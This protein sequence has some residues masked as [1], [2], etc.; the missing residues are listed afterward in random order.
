MDRDAKNILRIIRN[1]AAGPAEI[2]GLKVSDVHLD[3]PIPFVHLQF[4]DVRR[5][6][7]KDRVRKLPLVGLA[8]EAAKDALKAATGENLFNS[9]TAGDRTIDVM[10]NRLNKTIRDAGIEDR[11][12]Y[13][14]R[15]S[16]V[17]AMRDSNANEYLQLRLISHAATST[18]DRVYGTKDARLSDMQAAITKALDH[19]G[20][21]DDDGDC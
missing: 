13:S 4:N 6:K 1:T 20:Q 21:F 19:L 16:M 9:I 14:L 2:A 7:N 8:L 11:T 18:K 15:H 12:T 5:L 10:G 3:G 17:D